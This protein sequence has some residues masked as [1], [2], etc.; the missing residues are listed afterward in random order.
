MKNRTVADALTQQEHRI[1]FGRGS[2]L[3]NFLPFLMWSER[4]ARAAGL[5]AE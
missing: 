4:L 3:I 2:Y 1:I 5:D